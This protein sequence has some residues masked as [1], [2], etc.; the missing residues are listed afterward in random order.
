MAPELELIFFSILLSAV[1]SYAWWI[2]FRVWMLRQDLFVIRDRLWDSTRSEGGL[3]DPEH[4]RVRDSI[5]ALIR[6]APLLSLWTIVRIF[7]EGPE[8]KERAR[9]LTGSRANEALEQAVTRVSCYL[10]FQTISGLILLTIMTLISFRV[11]LPISLTRQKF[12]SLLGRI[13]DSVQIRDESCLL[14]ESPS[15]VRANI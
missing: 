11:R 8:S 15:Y 12:D 5:N 7:I 9:P 10:L 14:A 2:R 1:L 6:I 3:D 13:L 4:R